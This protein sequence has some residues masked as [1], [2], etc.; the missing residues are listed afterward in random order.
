MSVAWILK[1]LLRVLGGALLL[2]VAWIMSGFLDASLVQTSSNYVLGEVE[3]NIPTLLLF[4]VVSAIGCR[5]VFGRPFVRAFF[6]SLPIALALFAVSLWPHI[7]S[8]RML[9]DVTSD[10][11]GQ[12]YTDS[13]GIFSP[14]ADY[15]V[16]FKFGSDI[17]PNIND[18]L[19]K[20][21]R[22]AGCTFPQYDSIY[23]SN[24]K[25]QNYDNTG[26]LIIDLKRAGGVQFYQFYGCRIQTLGLDEIQD[27]YRG[28]L[29][30][31]L[32]Y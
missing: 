25:H 13:S 15:A 9:S 4:I 18:P 26:S 24:D 7:S 22:D 20:K 28:I 30:M 5:L 29:S 16:S 8:L 19:F 21:L 17:A 14:T 23:S 31:P 3:A 10:Y 6:L 2:F 12:M 32:R 27:G 1:T 11:S